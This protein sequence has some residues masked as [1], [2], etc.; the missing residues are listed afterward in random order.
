M[1]VEKCE[2]KK[3]WQRTRHPTTKTRYNEATN[4]VKAALWEHRGDGRDDFLLS[5]E[6]EQPSIH[7][8]RKKI[9]RRAYPHTP[10][11]RTQRPSPVPS[12]R[13]RRD[14]D[15]QHRKAVYAP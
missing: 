4:Q 3:L 9:M 7:K 10:P 13:P 2:A 5:I 6:D 1:L 8:L 14:Y 15:P 12:S 11:V